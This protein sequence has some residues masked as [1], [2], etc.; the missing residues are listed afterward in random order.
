MTRALS[1]DMP[2]DRNPSGAGEAIPIRQFCVN[3]ALSHGV[4]AEDAA[5]CV[6][7]FAR[8]LADFEGEHCLG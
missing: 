3:L 5:D 7:E 4:S 8:L 6:G 1:S 2:P